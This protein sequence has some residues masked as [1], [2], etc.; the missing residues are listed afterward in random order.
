M[1]FKGPERERVLVNIAGLSAFGDL[2]SSQSHSKPWVPL[3]PQPGL[4]DG[5][6]IFYLQ[7]INHSS[8]IVGGVFMAGCSQVT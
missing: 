8:G 6:P 1:V 7:P 5:P 2:P 4:P 3:G